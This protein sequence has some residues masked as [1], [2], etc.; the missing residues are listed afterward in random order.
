MISVFCSIVVKK[1]A[2]PVKNVKGTF[3]SELAVID[4]NTGEVEM[5]DLGSGK[6]QTNEDG[7]DT[8]NFEI[9]TPIF[10]DGFESGDVSAWSYTRAD[11]T[12]KKKA[13]NGQMTCTG[14]SGTSSS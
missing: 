4:N 6:F 3:M 8:F 10:A 13:D 14:N 1:N 9:P 7:F 5:F 11:F 2:K 12:N